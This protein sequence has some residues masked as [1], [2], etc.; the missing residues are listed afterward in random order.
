MKIIEGH[1]YRTRRGETVGPIAWDRVSKLWRRNPE[2][3][4][5]TGDYWHEDGMRL[6]HVEDD[7]DLIE[8]MGPP[9]TNGE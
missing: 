7:L 3:I 1:V 9:V 8:D 2:F 5:N 4:R 6:A